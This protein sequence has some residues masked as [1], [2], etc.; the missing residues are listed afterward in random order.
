MNLEE[1]STLA[2]LINAASD[3]GD[4]DALH[5]LALTCAEG[6]ENCEGPYRVI[7]RYFE[8]N[9][10]AGLADAS[11]HDLAGS[12]SWDQPN[13]ISQ[14]FALRK[15]ARD[16]GF[17]EVPW[18][19]RCQVRTN[20]GNAL[21]R[22]GRP[23]AAIEQWDA[24]L[25]FNPNFAMALGNKA[26]GLEAYGAA[27]FDG[28]HA[29]VVL[30]EASKYYG[31]ATA[32][33]AYWEAPHPHAKQIFARRKAAIDTW[34]KE[35]EFD[36]AVDLDRWSL[37]RGF[38]EQRYRRWCLDNRLL[39][40]PLNDALTLSVAAQDVLHLPSHNYAFSEEARY[41]RYYN[42]LKQ[43][44]VSARY[45]LFQALEC[46][47]PKYVFTHVLLLDEG[48]DTL[49]GFYLEE[50]KSAFRMAY[51]LFDKVALFLNEYFEV[52]LSA[53]AVTLRTI[54]AHKPKGQSSFDLRPVFQDQ[55][56]WML[57]GLYFLSKDILDPEF[58]DNAEPDSERLYELRQQ[59]EHR[60]LSF[61]GFC[62]P[63]GVGG[64]HEIIRLDKF[65]DRTLR[66][67]K[68]AREAI[69]YLS[70]AMHAEENR[71]RASQDREP[72][73]T[74]PVLSRPVKDFYRGW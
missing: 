55:K 45:R 51:G 7:L 23:V 61:S 44:Y 29:G 22:L 38:E 8:S 40:S 35:I 67:L 1:I 16:P 53:S 54:W 20:L 64:V 17:F 49:Y 14:I 60:F 11:A 43:E 15:A 26:R 39:L 48:E 47:D 57:R 62:E 46:D 3:E 63:E 33:E 69:I 37:G 28:G 52:G 72:F 6:A 9:A 13:L 65:E 21:N 59:A 18:D 74:M 73:L 34:L 25:K 50:L 12:W 10:Y 30:N 56:N 71:R 31:K 68:L 66:L 58:K 4:T 19:T 70:L 5:R 42:I 2:P 27:L 36:E 41:P 32:G 24:A